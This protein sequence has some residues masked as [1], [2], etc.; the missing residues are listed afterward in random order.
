[1]S[2]GREGTWWCASLTRLR[3]CDGL[4]SGGDEAGAADG[5]SIA[6]A[7]LRRGCGGGGGRAGAD[8]DLS[9]FGAAAD[10]AAAASAA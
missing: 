10:A 8:L 9:A 3:G 2:G 1:M 6:N 5:V 7:G 4:T